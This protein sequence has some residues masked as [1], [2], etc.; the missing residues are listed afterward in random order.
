M[1][2]KFLFGLVAVVLIA[3]LPIVGGCGP[4]ATEKTEI[5]FGG[6]LGF[7]GA[8]AELAV[9]INE[10]YELFVEDTNADGGI[11]VEEYGKK[12]P[13]RLLLYDDKSDAATGA[14]WRAMPRASRG[15]YKM[16]A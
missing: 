7:S 1:K 13:V 16:S 6:S 5:V 8:F 10:A 2:G 9:L 12:L 4:K 3:S 14:S 11:Y 15:F